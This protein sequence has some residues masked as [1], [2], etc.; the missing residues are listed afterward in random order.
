MKCDVCE[1]DAERYYLTMTV[2]SGGFYSYGYCA[3]CLSHPVIPDPKKP[4]GLMSA[5]MISEECYLI[6]SIMGT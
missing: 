2:E 4:A 6:N 1:N 5:T 3:R